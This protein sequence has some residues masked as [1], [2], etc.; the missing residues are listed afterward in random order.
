MSTGRLLTSAHSGNSWDE[1]TSGDVTGVTT[2]L[3]ALGTK[4]INA[5]IH[6]FLDVLRVSNH[7]HIEKPVFMQLVDNRLGRDANGSNEKLSAR[8][9]DDIDKLV[10]FTFGV[11][12]ASEQILVS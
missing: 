10:E 1:D 12:M 5:H 3:T 4:K 9:N 8:F 11:V 7:I 6:A 2:G